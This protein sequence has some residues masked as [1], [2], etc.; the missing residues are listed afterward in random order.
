MT[1][2]TERLERIRALRRELATLESE[3][4]GDQPAP[5]RPRQI[6]RLT[7][8]RIETLTAPGF[9]A[10]GNNLYLDAW[11]LP[12]RNWVFRY[13]RDGRARDLGLGS[14]PLVSLAEARE[15]AVDAHRKLRAG[16]DPVAERKAAKAAGRIE[17]AREMTFRACAEAY[18]K[19]QQAGWKNAKHAAQWQTTLETYVYP[20]L[21]S[22]PVRV[23]DTAVVMKVIE[24]IWHHKT[25]TASRVRGRIESVLDW[26]RTRGH[27]QGENPARWKGHLDN[28]LP[29]KSKVAPVRNLPALP[30]TELPAFVDA[31]TSQDGIGPLAPSLH[32][33]PRDHCRIPHSTS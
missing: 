31:L 1:N 11:N 7:S 24:P 19:A 18:M 10:D 15:A 21:G 2:S 28:L 6:N 3:R 17:S 29:R 14:Y 5:Q 8:R 33:C 20:I 9:Y 30:Y 23:V 16:I 12:R 25:E 13:R 22:L 26:A 4:P 32:P 27:R